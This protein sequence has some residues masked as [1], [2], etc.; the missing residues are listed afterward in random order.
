MTTGHSV[1]TQEF[2]TKEPLPRRV[3]Y[4]CRHVRLPANNDNNDNNDNNN[5]DNNDN[6]NTT[7]NDDDNSKT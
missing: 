6:D 2:L 3:P 1:E 4:L 7:N 5:N